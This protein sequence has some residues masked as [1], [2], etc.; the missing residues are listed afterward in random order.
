MIVILLVPLLAASQ[1]IKAD[2]ITPHDI[3]LETH[4]EVI[5]S[6]VIDRFEGDQ[7][8]ILLEDIHEQIIIDRTDLPVDS[9]EGTWLM[10]EYVEEEIIS[11]QI[12]HKKMIQ[13]KEEN[14]GLIM[15]LK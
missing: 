13:R 11:L 10:I 8:V 4:K 5:L 9:K 14:K 3:E 7:S 15:K 1:T 12:D 2:I 6:G